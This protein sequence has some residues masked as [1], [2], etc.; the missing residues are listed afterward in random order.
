M[1]ILFSSSGM[2]LLRFFFKVLHT[3]EKNMMI[4]FFTRLS[5]CFIIR[6]NTYNGNYFYPLLQ[7]CSY[8]CQKS[9]PKIA[10]STYTHIHTHFTVNI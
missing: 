2:K 1:A 7:N 8:L 9:S 5:Q 4:Q 3:K 6:I 10:F